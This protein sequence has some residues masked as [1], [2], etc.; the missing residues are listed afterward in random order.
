M[1]ALRLNTPTD[2]SVARGAKPRE[3]FR[4]RIGLHFPRRNAQTPEIQ[5]AVQP[6]KLLLF[7]H[8]ELL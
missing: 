5:F 6:S 2:E 1:S 7:S 4:W 3:P 8:K